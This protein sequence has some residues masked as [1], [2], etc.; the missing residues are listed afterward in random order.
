MHI[1]RPSFLRQLVEVVDA[2]AILS[3]AAC[4]VDVAVAGL[5]G[6]CVAVA[7]DDDGED[8]ATVVKLDA[9]DFAFHG[10]RVPFVLVGLRQGCEVFAL[11]NGQIR[12]GGE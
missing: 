2:I 5:D 8:N 4:V 10:V 1:P 3:V 7:M 12:V 6:E 9:D 11:R